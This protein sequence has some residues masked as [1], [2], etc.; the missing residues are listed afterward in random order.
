M[1]R[2]PSVDEEIRSRAVKQND[3]PKSR[4]SDICSRAVEPQNKMAAPRPI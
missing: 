1:S 2:K 4:K 3:S